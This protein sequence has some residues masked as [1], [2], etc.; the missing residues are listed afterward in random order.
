MISILRRNKN[1]NQGN[2]SNQQFA[3]LIEDF[4]DG[5]YASID[6]LSGP[7]ATSMQHL[8]HRLD[9]SSSGGTGTQ[10][11]E[12][13][14]FRALQLI[15]QQ[16]ANLCKQVSPA[17][18]IQKRIIKEIQLRTQQLD[19]ELSD[20]NTYLSSSNGTVVNLRDQ[21]E[22]NSTHV[23]QA[24]T[25]SLEQIASNLDS[26]VENATKVLSGIN[27]IG[28]GINLL[29]LNAAIEAARAGSHG[30]GFAVVA[31][32]VRNLA[33]TTMERAQTAAEQL[34]FSEIVAE[35]QQVSET[36]ATR[37]SEFSGDINIATTELSSLFESIGDQLHS[38]TD[39]TAFIFESLVQS[40]GT[41]E[42]IAEKD[43]SLNKLTDEVSMGMSEIDIQKTDISGAIPHFEHI[44]SK[45]YL[46]PD[47]AHDQLDDIRQR[48][49]IRVAIEP[50]FV[51]LSFREHPNEPL[52]G[53]DVEYAKAFAH[54][55]GV[56]C[57]FIEVPWDIAT[58]L[59]SAGL[60]Y[61][62]P[63]ADVVISA[64]P[65][66]ADFHNT[67]YSD[68]YTYLHWILA[69]RVGD[70][71]INSL[72]DLE[73]KVLGIINDP[74]A[75]QL[76]EDHGVRWGDNESVPGGKIKLANLIAYSDQSRIHDCL[77]DGVV[78]AF[79]VDLPIYHWACTNTASPW[80]GKLEILPGNVAPE[81]YYYSIAVAANASSYRLL[82]Q[83]NQFITEFSQRQE[84]T[85]IETQ[86]QGTPI[87]GNTSYKDLPGNLMGETE[88]EELYQEHCRKFNIVS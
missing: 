39:N 32:E 34:D 1:K 63:P 68:I 11:N 8:Q 4:L 18:D 43:E 26:K 16:T 24:I 29:A 71:S 54:Y 84:R 81:P 51:G 23:N 69:R 60:S 47:P 10:S 3:Q 37:L 13:Q 76:L 12:K 15:S 65:P 50:S 78:D 38:I 87:K 46:V 27:D 77:A 30:R 35:L 41:I 62:Q 25:E 79:G 82:N 6:S 72:N 83:A 80:Y 17:L 67:A 85:D 53:L 22:K 19:K 55:L 2:L 88:L 36:N 31:D 74:G 5:D 44:S 57:E 61:G 42:R 45:L 73:G 7:L 20:V 64:L 49:Y 75:F 56:E 86:W 70:T 28:K 59:L 33:S 40:D 66:S 58:E 21:I 14:L 52:K 9:P 48:G